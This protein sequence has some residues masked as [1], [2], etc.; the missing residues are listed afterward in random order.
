[1]VLDIT[2]SA[3]LAIGGA[4]LSADVCW[5]LGAMAVFSTVCTGIPGVRGLPDRSLW[6]PITVSGWSTLLLLIGAA[7]RC[8]VVGGLRG[9]MPTVYRTLSVLQT[10][11]LLRVKEIGSCLLGGQAECL[12]LQDHGLRRL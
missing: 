2:L 11:G 12:C 6:C 1:M 7:C 9:V 3:C 5:R 10:A 4:V 8:G